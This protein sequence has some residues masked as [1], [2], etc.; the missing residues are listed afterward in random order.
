MFKHLQ[1]LI[2]NNNELQNILF[3]DVQPSTEVQFLS[4]EENQLLSNYFLLSD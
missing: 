3:F 1:E 2:A 4:G